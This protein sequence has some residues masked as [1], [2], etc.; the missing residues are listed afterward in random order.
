MR[1]LCMLLTLSMLA[2]CVYAGDISIWDSRKNFF[3]ILNGYKISFYDNEPKLL[4]SE[5]IDEKNFKLNESM[6]AY[7]GYSVLNNKVYR[8]D[9]YSQI[10]V[11]PNVDGALNSASIPHKFITTEK[12]K[13]IG[14]VYIGDTYYRLIPSELENFVFLIDEKGYFYK[15]MGEIKGDNLV[16]LNSLFYPYPENLHMVNVRT[17]K[18][19]QTKPVQG[20]DLKYDGVRLD[21]IWFTYLQ[22]NDENGQ[23]GTFENMSFPI[24][25]G[26]ID[27]NGIGFRVISAD[28]NKLEYMVLKDNQL[29][30]AGN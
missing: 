7:K 11:R 24:N 18:S 30:P 8:K 22:F 9:F 10:Y 21:R 29:T 19:E 15:K 13:L 2:G 17:S 23:R 28:N 14:D 12:Y 6:T 5:F 20:F 1:K 27:I 16:L 3:D 4:K 26:L 25:S